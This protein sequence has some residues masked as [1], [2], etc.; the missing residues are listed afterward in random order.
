MKPIKLFFEISF[1]LAVNTPAILLPVKPDLL[2]RFDALLPALA[3][4]AI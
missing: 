3:I 2:G 1:F 4:V